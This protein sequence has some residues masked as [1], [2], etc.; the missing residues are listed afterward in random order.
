MGETCGGGMGTAGTTDH[1]SPVPVLLMVIGGTLG[2]GA[3]TLGRGCGGGESA[4]G[5]GTDTS[6][7]S[8]G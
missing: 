1:W 8:E 4:R 5:T 2:G 3:G 7:G 6:T